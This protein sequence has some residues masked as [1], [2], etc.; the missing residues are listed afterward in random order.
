LLA[1][2]A[3]RI[4]QRIV[5]SHYQRCLHGLYP[6][7]ESLFHGSFRAHFKTCA[8]RVET[9]PAAGQLVQTK[10]QWMQEKGVRG[11]RS[12]FFTD[13]ARL[14][15]Q[16]ALSFQIKAAC[17]FQVQAQLSTHA[18]RQAVAGAGRG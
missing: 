17:I 14:A 7:D 10:R 13:A 16:G 4:E 2:R 15:D 1:A 3:A 6:H 11:V 5:V 18:L 12:E 8:H 9:A